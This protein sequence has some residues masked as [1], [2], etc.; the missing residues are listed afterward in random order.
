MTLCHL[1]YLSFHRRGAFAPVRTSWSAAARLLADE[2]LGEDLLGRSRVERKVD[3]GL[4][5]ARVTPQ[6]P[7]LVDEL[8]YALVARA[9]EAERGSEVPQPPT[10]LR[11]RLTGV[12]DRR[13]SPHK[14]GI[15]AWRG[16]Q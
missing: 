11:D 1:A 5:V 3:D 2:E 7:V 4:D 6:M 16:L 13:E 10:R 15:D 12:V 9:R 14:S 8:P